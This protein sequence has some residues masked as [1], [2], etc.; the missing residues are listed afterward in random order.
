MACAGSPKAEEN[1]PDTVSP[2]ADE[3]SC[4]HKVGELCLISPAIKPHDLVGATFHN[5]VVT[6]DMADYVAEYIEYVDSISPERQIEVSLDIAAIDGRGTADAVITT[7][8]QVH[9]IDLK[10][11][12][13]RVEAEWNVQL[14]LYALGMLSKHPS[15]EFVLHIVQPRIN[16]YSVWKIPAKDLRRWAETT[17]AKAVAKTRG[18]RPRRTPGEVQCRWCKAAPT[19]KALYDHTF[20]V[21]QGLFE[22]D[23]TPDDTQRVLDNKALIEKFLKAVEENALKELIVGHPVQGYKL[24]AGRK[25]RKWSP[26]AEREI[27]SKLGDEAYTTKL[28]GIGDITKLLGKDFVADNT[29]TPVPKLILAKE[30]DKRNR[31]DS[32]GFN[33][34]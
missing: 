3:G 17:L 14:M 33:A 16:N 12:R 11:G 9:I 25:A 21:L 13:G 26:S 24:V 28:K 29:I 15:H 1:I 27:T 2:L 23:M 20:E 6:E 34:L 10:Y 8:S 5:T 22:A 4:A 19:C 18:P 30:G 32:I 7:H 31:I